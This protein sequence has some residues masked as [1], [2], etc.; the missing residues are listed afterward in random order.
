MRP[1]RRKRLPN[2]RDRPDHGRA[3]PGG[4]PPTWPSPSGCP[5]P[6]STRSTRSS[7][8]PPTS[9]TASPVRIAGVNV[10]KVTNVEHLSRRRSQ[11]DGPGVRRRP[12]AAGTGEHRRRRG[13]DGA[14]RRLGAADPHRR[15][16]EDPAAPLPR[17]QPLRR[18][19]PRQP[20]RAG[21]R[22]RRHDPGEPDGGRRP[23]RPGADDA[24]VGRPDQ[25]PGPARSVRQRADQV[26]RRRGLAPVLPDLARR[27][28]DT[29]RWSTRP[30][31][32]RSRTTSPASSRTSIRRSMRSTATRPGLQNLVTN[33]QTVTGSFAAQDQSLA[34][35]IAELPKT[36][37]AGQPALASLN[38]SL[39][40]VRA[41]AREVA[42]RREDDAGDARFGD[43]A[44]QAGAR[45]GLEARASRAG[46]RPAPDDSA[47]G[48][49]LA[50]DGPVPQ[51][52]P[53]ARELLQRGRHPLVAADDQRPRDARPPGKIFQELGYG[54]EGLNGESRTFDGNGEIIRVV[55]GGGGNTVVD[56]R[57]SR[58]R[59]R[60]GRHDAAAAARRPPGDQLLA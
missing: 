6:T 52:E 37:R 59:R 13:D 21:G 44:A 50:Q 8:P 41:F 54:L 34:R 11:V 56:S 35:G 17:G 19:P 36:L 5:G 24:A 15:D 4:R 47:P 20:E 55:A 9:G 60:P 16:D 42:A 31:S 18:H 3:D 30:S 39:P 43:A 58:R 2:C 53:R 33:L 32:A 25:R 27:L 10:G 46:Q 57:R 7:L 51:P 12:S 48:Q 1:T 14:R 26:R 49:A 29:P 40:Q 45:P 23:A 22:R 28:Q 38:D